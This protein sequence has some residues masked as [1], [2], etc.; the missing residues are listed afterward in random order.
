VNPHSLWFEILGDFGLGIFLYFIFIY[1][2][3]LW[4][5][6]KVYRE[7][8]KSNPYG[9]TSYT[10]VSLIGV[11]GGFV[12]TAF[13]PSSVISFSQMWLFYGLAATIIIR[14][15]TFLEGSSQDHLE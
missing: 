1:L 3:L 10:T 13:A 2:N 4:D 15:K 12:L 9:L 7:S 11:L 6:L 8:L 14:R 5:L